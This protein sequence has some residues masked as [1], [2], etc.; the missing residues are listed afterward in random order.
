MKYLDKKKV[1]FSHITRCYGWILT[2]KGK[3]LIFD[4]VE[5]Y[6]KSPIKTL[7]YYSKYN[8]FEKEVY[9]SLTEELK[10]YL[11]KNNILFVDASLSNV[12]CQKVTKNKYKL[13]IFDG[14]GGRRIGIKSW[15]YRKS[16]TF[17]K[18]KIKKQWK[19]FMQ[20]CTY[21]LS[22]NLKRVTK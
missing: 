18:Y 5:N 8:I 7:S 13:I 14:L 22:L 21:E 20:N 17:T 11:E 10:L 9:E 16:L 4:R 1:D 2:N 19:K 12:F 6:D 15:L 3:G